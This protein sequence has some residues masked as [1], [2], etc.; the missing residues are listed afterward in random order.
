MTPEFYLEATVC[1]P[2][3]TKALTFPNVWDRHFASNG[4]FRQESPQLQLC[5]RARMMDALANSPAGRRF[6]AEG[7][8]IH[9]G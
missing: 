4:Q 9:E 6:N 3:L 8:E 1:A 7:T 5:Q 2:T